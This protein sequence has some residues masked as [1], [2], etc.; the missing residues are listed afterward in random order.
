MKRIRS[1]QGIPFWSSS[2]FPIALLPR[3]RRLS[4][5][6][7]DAAMLSGM[8]SY[9]WE[10]T[11][12]EARSF[13]TVREQNAGEV[14]VMTDDARTLSLAV[15]AREDGFEVAPDAPLWLF[16]P[17]VWPVESRAWI[18]DNRVRRLRTM[19]KGRW[20]DLP[21]G[22]ADYFEVEASEQEVIRSYGLSP[23]PPGRVWLLRP[24][25]AVSDMEQTLQ[26][27]SDGAESAGVV[28]DVTPEFLDHTV[29][30]LRA[31]FEPA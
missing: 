13:A 29:R 14:P 21:W 25:P 10:G 12:S 16:L 20:G 31:L 18:R 9:T 24:P 27:L 7:I 22:A 19:I 26:L 2:P 23:R 5:Y 6:L 1:R 17:A 11:S 28:A 15:A 30:T 4:W 8:S 3:W